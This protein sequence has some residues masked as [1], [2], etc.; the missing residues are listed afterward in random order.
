M[1]HEHRHKLARSK[2]SV[3]LSF[4]VLLPAATMMHPTGASLLALGIIM[5]LVFLMRFVAH[6]EG[7]ALGEEE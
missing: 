1:L 4:A 2:A 3:W 7:R 6:L 5:A